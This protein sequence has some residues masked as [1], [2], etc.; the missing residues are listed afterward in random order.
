MI[1]LVRIHAH[2]CGDG[3][4]FFGESSERDR[5]HSA[6][7]GYSNNNYCLIEKFRDDFNA[8]F[9]VQM[10]LRKNRKEVTVRSIRIYKELLKLFG[11]LS[12]FK[13]RIPIEIK[14]LDTHSKMEW[15]KSFFEDEAYH[16][17]KYN[18]L[19]TKSMNLGGLKDI[20]EILDSLEINS[21]ITGPNCDKSYYITIPRFDN[22]DLFK[23]FKKQPA[24][25]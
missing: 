4:M 9:K 23:D 22:I 3:F 17:K 18:R 19:K 12:S 2:L 16:E 1:E 10:K 13:W 25:K 21:V 8:V 6:T 24:R 20:K 11:E 15:L 14:N 5:K 7:V